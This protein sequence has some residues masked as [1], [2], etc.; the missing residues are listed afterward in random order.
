MFSIFISLSDNL[1]A[2]IK[3]NNM[4]PILFI[5][6]IF[7]CIDFY[8]QTKKDPVTLTKFSISNIGKTIVKYSYFE[9]QGVKY[10]VESKS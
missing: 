4:K 5:L 2:S 3:T 7:L 6:S 1:P 10:K 8:S 9:S